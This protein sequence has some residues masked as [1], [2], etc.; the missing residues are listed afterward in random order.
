MVHVLFL[1]LHKTL[2][3]SSEQHQLISPGNSTDPH[4]CYNS[5][6]KSYFLYSETVPVTWA[7]TGNPL[8]LMVSKVTSVHTVISVKYRFFFTM[9]QTLLRVCSWPELIIL[10]FIFLSSYEI[11]QI[12]TV[13]SFYIFCIKQLKKIKNV[14]T[15]CNLIIWILYHFLHKHKKN[16]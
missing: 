12:F 16:F 8:G 1:L 2:S 13:I 6:L 7:W 9:L 10:I 14:N 5:E 3:N 15:L 11:I 4:W